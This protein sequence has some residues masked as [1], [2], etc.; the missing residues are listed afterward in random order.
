ML[1]LFGVSFAW[2]DLRHFSG[3][4]WWILGGEI[5]FVGW[6]IDC[7]STA[8]NVASHTFRLLLSGFCFAV[9]LREISDWL[10]KPKVAPL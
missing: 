9:L 8:L 10:K 3:L 6:P 2:R 4:R 1:L 7:G 5:V